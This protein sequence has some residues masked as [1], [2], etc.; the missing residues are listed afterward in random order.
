MRKKARD[1]GIKIGKLPTGKKNCITD[2][3]GVK[4]GHVTL[5]YELGKEGDYACTGV[6]AILPHDGN[7]FQNKVTAASYVINGFGKSAGLI[8]V[9]ELGVIE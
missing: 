8:Q 6:T 1:L 9:N 4:V 3:K 2:V 5:D 7:L